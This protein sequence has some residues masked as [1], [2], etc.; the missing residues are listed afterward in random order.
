MTTAKPEMPIPEDLQTWYSVACDGVEFATSHKVVKTLIDR[1]ARLEAE[2]REAREEIATHV[3]ALSSA[4]T[5]GQNQYAALEAE[6]EAL[7]GK[8]EGKA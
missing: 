7:K 4:L 5:A 2:L 6:N 1:I 8:L 3:A